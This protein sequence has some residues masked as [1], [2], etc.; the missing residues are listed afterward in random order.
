MLEIGMKAPEFCNPNQDDVEICL[1]DLKGKWIVLYFYPK[2]NTPGCT[3]EACDFTESEAEFDDL[4]AVIVGVSPD[5]PK[6][7]RG[8]I[9]KQNLTITLLADE[10]KTLCEAYG[11]WQEKLNYGKKYMGVVRSTFIIN[12]KGEIAAV[13][14]NV[15]VRQKKKVNG[16][17]V[18]IK[19][20]DVVKQTLE[21]LQK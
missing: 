11:V 16:E 17:T 4:D 15:K 7:H 6:K 18:E 14:E 9:E 12:P 20:S 5:S 13:W 19:H 21:E 2:D 8:F 1:R 3:N 10:E